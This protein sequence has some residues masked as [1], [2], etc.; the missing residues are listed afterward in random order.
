MDMPWAE[1]ERYL[2]RDRDPAQ[3]PSLARVQWLE[4]VDPWAAKDQDGPRADGTKC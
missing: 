4:R 1:T 3:R 2:R